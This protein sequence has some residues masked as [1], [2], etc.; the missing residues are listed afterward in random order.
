MK[1]KELIGYLK[2]CD[3]ETEADHHRRHVAEVEV[4]PSRTAASAFPDVPPA[5]LSPYEGSP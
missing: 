3:P 1:V 5:L 4:S 2:Q